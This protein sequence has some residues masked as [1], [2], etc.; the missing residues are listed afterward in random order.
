MKTFLC[1]RYKTALAVIWAAALPGL[2]CLSMSG[3][4][5]TPAVFLGPEEHLGQA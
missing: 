4:I 1:V 5:V 2:T 3:E